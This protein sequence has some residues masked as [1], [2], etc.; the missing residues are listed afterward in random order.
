MCAKIP[1]NISDEDATFTVLA[2]I[3]LQGIR[4]AN[5]TYG[6]TFV[7][8]GLGI[9]GIITAQLLKANGCEVIGMDPDINKCLITKKLGIN[10]FHLESTEDPVSYCENKTNNIGVDG[11]LITAS[12]SNNEPMKLLQS[13]VEK[14]QNSISWGNRIKF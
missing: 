6:E 9:I 11:V 13:H 8:S 2:S 7:V 12:T 5:P 14:R 10:T 4:L 1:E 3:A